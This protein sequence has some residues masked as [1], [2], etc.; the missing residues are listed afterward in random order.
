MLPKHPQ[1]LALG[2]EDLDTM[3]IVVGHVHL[4][5]PVTGYVVWNVELSLFAAQFPEGAG[6]S[7]VRVQDMNT[8]TL[9][10]I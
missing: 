9:S 4:P 7:E 5:S 1:E 2:C 3:V 10:Y 6:E 8:I